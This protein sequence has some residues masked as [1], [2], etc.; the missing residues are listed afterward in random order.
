MKLNELSIIVSEICEE[1]YNYSPVIKSELVNRE[2]PSGNANAALYALLRDMVLYSGIENLGIEGFTPVRGLYNILLK[3]TGIHKK[4]KEGNYVFVEPKNNNLKI[5]WDYTDQYLN[6]GKTTAIIDIFEK[7]KKR[8]FGIKP[9][10]FPFLITAYIMTRSKIIA[11]YREGIYNPEITDFLVEHLYTNPKAIT[12]KYIEYDMVAHDVINNI[13]MAIN[14]ISNNDELNTDTE[15]LNI[16]KKL[17]SMIDSLHPWVLRTKTLTKKTTELREIIKASNDPNKLIFEDIL[18]IFQ[19]DELLEG[20]KSS[21]NE[22]LQV[23]PSMIQSVGILLTSELDIPLV[24]SP[25]IEKLNQRAKNIK[26]VAGDFQIDAFAARLS[27]FN[28]T[29]ND[30]A[31][32][33]SLANSKPQKDWIDLDIENAKKEIIRLCIEFKKA[34]LFTKIKNRTP[35]RQAIAFI[36]GIGGKSEI[37]TGEFSLLVEKKADVEKTKEKI[38]QLLKSEKDIALILTA[39]AETSIEYLRKN[40]EQ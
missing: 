10:L 20:L 38:K 31:G 15:P 8:P 28:T 17:V 11:V 4:S 2:R 35:E 27:T 29:S 37:T 24:T 3:D 1:I 13:V 25:Q 39:L 33:I 6:S 30:I 7:W 26:G 40:N 19:K 22:L 34:E 16:A 5:L 36:S 9:G 14:D 12:L 23:Y 32:I 18:E 21:M